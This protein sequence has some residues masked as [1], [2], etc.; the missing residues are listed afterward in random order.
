MS[1]TPAEEWP[2]HTSHAVHDAAFINDNEP[3]P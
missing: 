3:Q 2:N 1:D